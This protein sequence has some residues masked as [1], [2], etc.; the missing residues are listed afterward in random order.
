MSAKAALVIT[1]RRYI[2]LLV[3]RC[4]GEG[5][6]IGDDIVVRVVRTG[7]RRVR[8][9]IAAPESVRILREELV[10]T[11]HD[12]EETV[13]PPT[14]SAGNGRFK[15]LVVEDNEIHAKLV[16]HSL[17]RNP[18]IDVIV[19]GSGED[20]VL[21]LSHCD[22]TNGSGRPDLVLLD[23]LLPGMPGL[24]VLK[25]IR[26][27]PALRNIPVVVLTCSSQES[28]VSRCLSAGANAFVRKDDGYEEMRYSILRITDFWMHT[29]RVA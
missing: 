19:A 20:A 15:V 13:A 25:V 24:E 3:E 22:P 8:V 27:L 17:A 29:R 14:A 26:S 12:R 10:R 7:A 9:G 18:S 21:R 1:L 16:R 23:L 28:D 4:K 6:H 2:M 5:I 11:T